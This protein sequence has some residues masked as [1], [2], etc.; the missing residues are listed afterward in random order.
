M[1][2]DSKILRTKL[3]DAHQRI[4]NSERSLAALTAQIVFLR[5]ALDPRSLQE[6]MALRIGALG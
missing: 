2:D 6:M 5:D 4:D 1:R 3:D